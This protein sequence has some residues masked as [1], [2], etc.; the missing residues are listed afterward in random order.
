MQ[1]ILARI[2]I[3]L[4]AA[5]LA[6]LSLWAW[7]NHAYQAGRADQQ[8]ENALAAA[9]VRNAAL[10]LAIRQRDA[11]RADNKD[12]ADKVQDIQATHT[13]ELDNAKREADTFVDGVRTGRIRLHVPTRPTAAGPAA[14][15]GLPAPAGPAGPEPAQALAEL[16]PAAAADLAG[17]TADGDAA[18][19]DLNACIDQ[20]AAA[21][22][23]VARWH[24][25]VRIG[26]QE[27]TP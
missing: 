9:G 3:W 17:I 25:T 22:A 18:I 24:N 27:P 11:A 5:A 13:K 4:L 12:L 14:V 20:Y 6:G 19:L 21:R 7:Q 26:E 10:E 16:D 1:A 8:A 15:P 2:A 23:A